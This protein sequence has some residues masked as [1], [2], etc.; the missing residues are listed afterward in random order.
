VLPALV[1]K[2][3]EAKARGLDRAV[4]WAPGKPRREFLH[5]DDMAEPV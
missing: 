3:H 5:S 1:R 4:V 2:M